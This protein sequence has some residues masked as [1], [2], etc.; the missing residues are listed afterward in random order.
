MISWTEEERFSLTSGSSVRYL[1]ER[2]VDYTALRTH[3]VSA[4]IPFGWWSDGR[5]RISGY[6]GVG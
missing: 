5:V 2:S 4:G 3:L 1:K 6:S